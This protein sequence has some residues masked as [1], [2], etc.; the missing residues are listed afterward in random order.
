MGAYN[1]PNLH[2]LKE[3]CSIGAL[4]NR[5]VVL[6]MRKQI[7]YADSSNQRGILSL[8]HTRNATIN[9]RFYHFF[10]FRFGTKVEA[11]V[12][13]QCVFVYLSFMYVTFKYFVASKYAA[14]NICFETLSYIL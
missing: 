12:S 13:S 6:V 3:N 10:H 4:Q 8:I 7:L 9:L 14:K 2:R 5:N 1:C 11:P